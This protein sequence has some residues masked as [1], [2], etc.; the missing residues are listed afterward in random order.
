M[1][2]GMLVSKLG[3]IIH[4]KIRVSQTKKGEKHSSPIEDKQKGEKKQREN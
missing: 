3:S 1:L 2:E 4:K